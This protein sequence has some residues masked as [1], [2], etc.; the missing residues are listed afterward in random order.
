MRASAATSAYKGKV[1]SKVFWLRCH[2]F[3]ERVQASIAA[4]MLAA[5][6]SSHLA[7]PLVM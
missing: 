4:L 2:F 5:L 6:V 7:I 1:L 3:H